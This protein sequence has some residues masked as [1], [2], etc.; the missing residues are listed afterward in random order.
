VR[1]ASRGVFAAG[2]IR[3]THFRSKR[4]WVEKPSAPVV[5]NNLFLARVPVQIS[6]KEEIVDVRNQ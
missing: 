3:F 4:F 1:I 6:Q 5:N 2:D